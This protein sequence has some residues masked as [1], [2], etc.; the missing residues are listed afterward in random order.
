MIEQILT[1]DEVDALLQGIS[2]ESDVLE[3][4][5][6]A[7]GVRNYDISAQERIVRG[8][9]P[10]LEVV[11]ERFSRNLRTGL[12]GLI[13]RSAEVSTGEIKVQK[14]SAF[15]R[16][17]PVPANLNI[18]AIRPLRVSG[19]IVCEPSLIFAAI[20][21][22]FG[23]SG[24]FH[25]RIEGRDFSATEQRVIDRLV[26]VLS[27]EYARA[28][29]GIYPIELEYQRS[30][31]L[32]QFATIAAP[33]EI[34]VTTAFSMEIGDM[35]GTVHFCLPY[36]SLEPIRD[37]LHASTQG[38]SSNADGRWLSL[39]KGQIQEAELELVAELAHAPT[40]VEQL[41][42][43]APGDFVELDMPRAIQAKV[44]GVPV[45]DCHYGTS[46]GRYA[47]KV[48][49]LLASSQSSWIGESHGN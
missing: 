43:L 17:I 32:P 4:E 20:D 48:N 47:L 33:S 28:W 8:R 26:G 44:A 41:L 9:M 46:N 25:T 39:I 15:L 35:S 2:A 27:T 13:H 31:M 49:Q 10:N 30:E 36:S 42:S 19:L 1:Q 23:G 24:K 37:V 18:V 40:T 14:Y 34:V 16:E 6:P 22:L 5:A 21:A 29:A 38:D 45:L 3:P 7:D 11:H 12:F